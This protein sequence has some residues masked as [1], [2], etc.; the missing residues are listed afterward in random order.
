[1]NQPDS[2]VVLQFDRLPPHNTEA[3]QCTIAS[4]ML[5][6]TAQEFGRIRRMLLGD[7]F[8][9]ADHQIIFEAMCGVWDSGRHCDAVILREAL[10]KRQ[11]L[12][13]IGGAAYLAKLLDTVPAPTHG[14]YYAKIVKE[15]YLLRVCIA[16]S[17]E[18]LWDCFRPSATDSS[19]EIATKAVRTL[20]AIVAERDTNK[21]IS[22]SDAMRTVVDRERGEHVRRLSTGLVDLDNLVGGLP[23]GKFTQVGARPGMGKSLI[24]KQILRNAALAGDPVGIVSIEETSEKIAENCLSAASGIE[25]NHIAYGNLSPEEW[26]EIV[27]AQAKMN[28]VKFF[29][30]DQP[31]KLSEVESAITM[32]A[33]DHK[34][35]IVAVDYIQCIDAGEQNE[36]REITLVSRTIKAAFKRLNVAG[37]VAV[38]L[39]RGPTVGDG[40]RPAL[41]D[42]RGSGSLEQDGDLILLLHSEDYYRRERGDGMRDHKLEIIVAKNKDGPQSDVPVRVDLKTQ[43]VT[44]WHDSDPEIPF[45]G[46]T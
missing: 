46:G 36:N 23:R 1:M 26:R 40:R 4:M 9:Q 31:T 12:D 28:E 17:N 19:I 38:Q 45:T 21:I 30:S 24:L 18:I 35:S 13:E 34:C 41:K 11:L 2:A 29:I 15:N 16:T 37:L 5:C 43:R 14:E 10:L 42:L 22:L 8:Y 20:S 39:N 44:D 33:V 7:Y 3:E 27:T 25:N 32:L 6:I